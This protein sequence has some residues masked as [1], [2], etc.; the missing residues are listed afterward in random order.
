MVP[1]GVVKLATMCSFTTEQ[2]IEFED[3]ITSHHKAYQL[4]PE[5][6]DRMRPKHHFAMH[7]A[8]LRPG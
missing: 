2:I 1:H 7:L 6:V 8:S 5:Y 4:V 3:A